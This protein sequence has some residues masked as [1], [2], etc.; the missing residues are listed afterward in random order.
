MGVNTEKGL[1]HEKLK[2]HTVKQYL[3]IFLRGGGFWTRC[4]IIAQPTVLG[5]RRAKIEAALL[6]LHHPLLAAVCSCIT[7]QQAPLVPGVAQTEL[8]GHPCLEG[9]VQSG[10]SQ[11]GYHGI[12]CGHDS[13]DKL[14]RDPH[15]QKNYDL[16]WSL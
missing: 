11:P 9:A 12:V 13:Q 16:L 8:R 1:C 15:C 2:C 14:N 5:A 6:T 7:E 3:Y 10:D 4:G